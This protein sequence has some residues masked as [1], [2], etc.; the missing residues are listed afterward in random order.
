MAEYLSS[1]GAMHQQ[2]C[3]AATVDLVAMMAMKAVLRITRIPGLYWWFE[4]HP[5]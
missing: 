1:S 2:M 4:I 5:Q 3:V